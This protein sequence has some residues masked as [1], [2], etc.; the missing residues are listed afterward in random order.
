MKNVNILLP[1]FMLFVKLTNAQ[2]IEPSVINSSGGTGKINGYIV[3]FSF[4]EVSLA[5]TYSTPKL[6]VTQGV[7]QNEP[8]ID[9]TTGT[10]ATVTDKTVIAKVYPNP[11]G[12]QL[13]IEA[14]NKEGGRM[15]YQL[16]D[17][18]G[19]V[20]ID[21]SS[22]ISLGSSNEV[23]DLSQLAAGFYIL[24]LSISDTAQSTVQTWKIQKTN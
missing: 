6:I 1:G 17:M 3:D 7:L 18:N 21:K 12:H 24:H 19:K 2:S 4:C 23:L 22:A 5:T 16:T 20:L 9:H 13:Y 10:E 8:F 14:L 15:Q 11:S